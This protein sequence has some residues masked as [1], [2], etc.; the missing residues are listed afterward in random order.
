[1]ESV[2]VDVEYWWALRWR[3]SIRASELVWLI[4]GFFSGVCNF[5][6]QCEE[7]KQVVHQLCPGTEVVCHTGRRG[8]NW[9]TNISA[10]LHFK[11][12]SFDYS[13]IG[14]FEVQVNETLVHSKLSN[15]AFPDYNDVARNV[16]LAAEGKPVERAKE[17]PITDCTIQW[18]GTMTEFSSRMRSDFFYFSGILLRQCTL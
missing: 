1:M 18:R 13:T 10:S 12:L 4:F 6:S 14:A 9:F 15:L 7:L 11:N 8:G 16:R 5:K 2:K 17:Q 3:R